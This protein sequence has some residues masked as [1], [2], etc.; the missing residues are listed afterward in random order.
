M[1]NIKL[2]IKYTL[3]PIKNDQLRDKNKAIAYIISKCYVLEESIKYSTDGDV[4]SNYTIVPCKSMRQAYTKDGINDKF[5]EYVKYIFTDYEEAKAKRFELNEKIIESIA[6]KEG[7]E[8]ANQKKEKIE[9]LVVSMQKI[10]KIQEKSFEVT[11]E[12][13]LTLK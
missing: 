11:D 13:K 2:P 6:K 12:K 9:K 1:D 3:I 10:Q 7:E 4:Y 5:I 8:I